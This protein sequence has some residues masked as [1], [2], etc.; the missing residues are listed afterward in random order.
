MIRSKSNTRSSDSRVSDVSNCSRL[1]EHPSAA[2]QYNVVHSHFLPYVPTTTA[3]ANAASS[4]TTYA[5][6]ATATATASAT[7]AA[8][9]TATVPATPTP[10]PMPASNIIV[11]TTYVSSPGTAPACG[12]TANPDANKF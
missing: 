7:A 4:T 11:T 3:A 1:L 10:T 5:A 8:S 9:A 2:S 6:P 12:M